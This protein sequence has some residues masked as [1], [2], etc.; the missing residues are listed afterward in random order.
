MGGR[1]GGYRK[2]LTLIHLAST[3]GSGCQ[4]RRASPSTLY[5]HTESHPSYASFPSEAYLLSDLDFT[6]MRMERHA[7]QDIET[8]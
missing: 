4:T 6:G 3:P 2:V 7:E 5:P 8:V 1:V